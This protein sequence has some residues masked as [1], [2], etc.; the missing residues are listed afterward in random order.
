MPSVKSVVSNHARQ[1]MSTQKSSGKPICMIFCMQDTVASI[2][3]KLR[4]KL[5]QDEY[6]DCVSYFEVNPMKVGGVEFFCVEIKFLN[7]PPKKLENLLSK[8]QYYALNQYIPMRIRDYAKKHRKNCKKEAKLIH[9]VFCTKDQLESA[10]PGVR[11]M[12]RNLHRQGHSDSVVLVP[13]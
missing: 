4:K 12:I 7:N 3:E 2:K 6:R 5:V 9:K 8:L 10:D 13:T 11:S 1:H